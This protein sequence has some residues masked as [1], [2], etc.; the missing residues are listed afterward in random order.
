MRTVDGR[1]FIANLRFIEQ[2]GAGM[3]T[4][5]K[6]NIGNVLIRLSD[7]AFCPVCQKLIKLVSFSDAAAIFKTDEDDITGLAETFELHRVHNRHG[8]VM[9]CTDS[10]FRCFDDRPTRP[11]NPNFLPTSVAKSKAE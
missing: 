10:L 2:I 4:N 3:H 11:L 5:N 9:I 6:L 8:K 1:N 7:H